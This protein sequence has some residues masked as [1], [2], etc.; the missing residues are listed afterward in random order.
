MRSNIY[1]RL[2]R[3]E[4]RVGSNIGMNMAGSLDPDVVAVLN[5]YGD[6]KAA[7]S[8]RGYRGGVPLAPV[9]RAAEVYGPSYTQEQF[10][11]L[12]IRTGLEGRG[13]DEEEVAERVPEFLELFGSWDDDLHIGAVD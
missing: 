4:G 9:N 2:E 5:A 12:A 1:G 11:E 13:Y 3:L 8:D 6:L 10:R 7:M